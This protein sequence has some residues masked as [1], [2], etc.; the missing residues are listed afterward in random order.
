MKINIYVTEQRIFSLLCTISHGVDHCIDLGDITL[1]TEI[2]CT[3]PDC[4]FE[5]VEPFHSSAALAKHRFS[6]V[7]G[8]GIGNSSMVR[9][10]IL[11]GNGGGATGIRDSK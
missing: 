1:G 6:H 3:H 10:I 9:V 5:V 2:W 7:S 4:L 11:P 8:G